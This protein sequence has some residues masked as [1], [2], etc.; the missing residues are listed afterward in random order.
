MDQNSLFFYCLA[1]GNAKREV[2]AFKLSDV[3]KPSHSLNHCSKHLLETF[4]VK[5]K[6]NTEEVHDFTHQPFQEYLL[7][8]SLYA[9]FFIIKTLQFCLEHSVL[10]LAGV[11]M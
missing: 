1:V 10:M 2:C 7:K 6:K 4:G 5:I 8:L 9:F 3:F 11:P